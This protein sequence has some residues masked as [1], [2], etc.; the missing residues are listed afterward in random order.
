MIL[1]IKKILCPTDFSEPSYEVLKA[2]NELANFFSAELVLVFV[3]STAQILPGYYEPAATILP[4]ILKE[5]E[6]SA[7]KS[8]QQIAQEIIAKEVKART[9]LIQGSPADKIV[10][11]AEEETV[12]FIVIATHGQSGWK[13]LISGSVTERVV[14]LADRPVLTIHALAEDS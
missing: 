8:L 11:A 1:P 12:D 3:I 9:L 10:R 14:R 5:V 13:K 7:K 6:E 4:Q 2:G